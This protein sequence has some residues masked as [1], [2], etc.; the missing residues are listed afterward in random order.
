MTIGGQRRRFTEMR[1][2][3]RFGVTWR[4]DRRRLIVVLLL[5][6]SKGPDFTTR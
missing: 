2:L 1:K 5:Q 4:A 6:N 3:L